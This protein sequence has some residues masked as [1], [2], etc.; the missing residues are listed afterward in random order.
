MCTAIIIISI[1]LCLVLL[2][3]YLMCPSLKAKRCRPFFEKHRYFAHRGLYDNEKTP[4]NS[5]DSFRKAV[6]AGYGIELDV[7]LTKDKKLVVFHD[8]DTSRLC[9]KKLRVKDS[10]FDELR[11]LRLLGTDCVIPTF[12]EVLEVVDGKVPMVI[13]IK[14]EDL[15][16]EVNP[17]TSEAL[18]AYGGEYVVESFNPY[19]LRWWKKH[20][21]EVIRGQLAI[22][23]KGK[24]K[25]IIR[26]RDFILKNMFINFFSKPD[27]LSL[28]FHAKKYYSFRYVVAMGCF[29]VAWTIRS[30][31]DLDNAS[32]TFKAFIFEK[33][34]IE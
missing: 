11:S 10:A 7:W 27:F 29:P 12:E 21:P 14:G 3:L 23:N 24:R 33:G 17:Y 32:D 20:R 4:E 25:L 13:E 26:L 34:M 2:D 6:D 5:L 31:D 22:K 9:G 1:I 15:N 28:D 8:N 18:A 30:K 19:Y 16:A